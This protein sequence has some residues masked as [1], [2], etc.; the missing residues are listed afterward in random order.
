LHAL[1]NILDPNVV[2]KK[3][4]V[5]P[6]FIDDE[7]TRVRKCGTTEVDVRLLALLFLA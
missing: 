7:I 5:G 3:D 1:E 6:N 2:R 4:A